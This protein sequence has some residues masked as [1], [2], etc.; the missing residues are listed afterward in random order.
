LAL[1]CD[2]SFV[3]KKRRKML[4]P[5]YLMV[6]RKI[7]ERLSNTG[8]N[9]ALTGSC[10]FALQGIDVEP[11]DID[12]QTNKRGAYEIENLFSEFVTSKIVFSCMHAHAS[13]KRIRSYLGALLIDGIKVEIMG[14]IQIL[15]EDG[16]WEEPVDLNL[17][18]Q[19]VD[20]E[21]LKIPVLSLDYEY[22]A[23]LKLGRKEKAEMLRKWLHC[24]SLHH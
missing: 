5:S 2:L 21:G 14:D 6:L 20:I 19:V 4:D 17:H 10:S 15:G 8:I 3:E 13:A 18:K 11:H 22:Q 12:V 9:W 1:L 16:V 23:Y 24:K 7:C